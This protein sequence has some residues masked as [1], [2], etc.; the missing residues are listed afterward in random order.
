MAK[1]EIIDT[2]ESMEL[3]GFLESKELMELMESMK[4]MKPIRPMEPRF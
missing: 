4:F 2:L 1:M 3:G